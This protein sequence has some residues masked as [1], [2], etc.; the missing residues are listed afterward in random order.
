MLLELMFHSS[1]SSPKH[2]SVLQN[3]QY[4]CCHDT[5][6]FFNKYTLGM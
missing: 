6:Q 4:G 5:A 3:V 1:Q 2:Y